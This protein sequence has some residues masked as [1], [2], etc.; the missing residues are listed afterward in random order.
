MQ[1]GTP[2][3]CAP[4]PWTPRCCLRRPGSE[5]HWAGPQLEALGSTLR[6]GNEL[7][8]VT[9]KCRIVFALSL[10]STAGLNSLTDR[11]GVWTSPS[12]VGSLWLCWPGDACLGPGWSVPEGMLPP[13]V[14]GTPHVI[15][16]DTERRTW[17]QVS[18]AALASCTI[19]GPTA[20]PD[21]WVKSGD[22]ALVHLGDQSFCPEQQ[23]S[24]KTGR[25]LVAQET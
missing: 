11:G 13:G 7:G 2:G 24:W 1:V 20:C 22:T 19:C 4:L 17:R 21:P 8:S 14:L 3:F 5:C 16:V 9:W 10:L 12:P 23:R 25:A 6:W 18:T 15:T